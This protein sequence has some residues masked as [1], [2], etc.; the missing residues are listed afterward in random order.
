MTAVTQSEVVGGRGWP[1][2]SSGGQAKPSLQVKVET[3]WGQP[4][5]GKEGI[6]GWMRSNDEV[7][8]KVS[9]IIVVIS[10]S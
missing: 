4:V 7:S 3:E 10:L 8:K 1:I 9:D 2:Q 6:V 5:N